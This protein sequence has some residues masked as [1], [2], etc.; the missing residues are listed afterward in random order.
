MIQLFE[1]IDI[2]INLGPNG[3]VWKHRLFDNDPAQLRMKSNDPCRS[4]TKSA[5]LKRC[6]DAQ[7]KMIWS[8]TG[9]ILLS[10]L[11]IQINL[12]LLSDHVGSYF[13]SLAPNL[14]LND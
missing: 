8:I 4:I 1:H 11:M 9:R 13:Y 7:E 10:S 5:R 2:K 3:F 12:I 6:D 14:A